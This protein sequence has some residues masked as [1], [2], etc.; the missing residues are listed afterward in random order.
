MISVLAQPCL[1][2]TRPCSFFTSIIPSASSISISIIFLTLFSLSIGASSQSMDQIYSQGSSS[3]SCIKSFNYNSCNKIV[4]NTV[5]NN[6]VADDKPQILQWLSPLEPQKRHQQICDNRHD[7]VGEWIFGR[8][9][10]LK[11]RTGEDGSHP[12]IFCEGDPGVGKTH[13]R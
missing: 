12:V 2:L 11:W 8:D 9:E 3:S 4:N 13:L 10:Y 5:V 7:G 1:A 6:T